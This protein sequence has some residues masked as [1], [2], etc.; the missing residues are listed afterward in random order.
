MLIL[1]PV[2]I[3][4]VVASLSLE[5]GADIY[6]NPSKGDFNL[7]MS[8]FARNEKVSIIIFSLAG[9]I[10]YT[11]S[12]TVDDNGSKNVKVLTGNILTS[13]NYYVVAKGNSTFVRAK[14]L[15][16]K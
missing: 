15:I 2:I 6:P 8:H 9:Q 16:C 13:G 14:L 1:E 3:P 10:M 5:K 11:N 7:S 12:Y 4:T